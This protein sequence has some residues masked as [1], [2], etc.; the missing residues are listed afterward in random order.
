[1]R[2]VEILGQLAVAR[3][4]TIA[5]HRR[6]TRPIFAAV[7]LSMLV[8]CTADTSFVASPGSESDESE[9]ESESESDESGGPS[10]ATSDDDSSDDDSSDHSCGDGIVDPDEQCDDGNT[11]DWDACSNACTLPQCGDGQIQT[12]E[13][14]DL[15]PANGPGSTCTNACQVNVCGDGV[16]GPGETCDDGNDIDD[17]DCPN[18]CVVPGCGN[19]VLD[20][21]EECE[22]DN[23]I[24]G[25]GCTNACLFAVCGDGIVHVGH[26]ACDD[27]NPFDDDECTTTC[28]LAVCGDGLVQLDEQ[29]DD[30]N[31]VANDGCVDC[32]AQRVVQLSVGAWSTCALLDTGAVRC[33]GLNDFGQLGYGHTQTIGDDEHPWTAGD[34]PL[35]GIAVE[36]GLGHRH[37]C[38][39]LEGGTVRCWGANNE[40]QLGYGHTETIGDNETPADAG[41]VDV[42]GP[43]VQLA[44][45]Y[46][47]TC[48][49]LESGAVRCWGSGNQALGYPHTETIGDDETPADAGDIDLGGTAVAIAGKSMH[50]CALMTTGGVRCWGNNFRS[51]LGYPG[52]DDDPSDT[53]ASLGDVDLGPGEVASLVTSEWQTC[54]IMVGGALRCWGYTNWETYP[55]VI[56]SI[57]GND[58]TPAEA[59]DVE[60][61]DA[62]VDL[63]LASR[64]ACRVDPAGAV[65]C[66]GEES[67][68]GM[69]GYGEYYLVGW[70]AG[71]APIVQVGDPVAAIAGDTQHYC[72]LTQAGGVRCWGKSPGY[73]NEATVGDDEWPSAAGYIQVFEP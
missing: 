52:L 34:V 71:D 61:T 59:G 44:V 56:D 19:G 15:G 35:G 9:S 72:A 4:R 7:S 30:A 38:A 45:G 42:G 51:A 37:A 54:A 29:C 64:G 50:T 39:R 48:A 6:V 23:D 18:T 11:I 60:L 1:M 26:E 22:D 32:Q 20:P 27:G 40:G 62:V 66:W 2:Q 31:N 53:P 58:E 5:S 69:H 16:L 49:L 63:A 65:R 21:G 46:I 68:F 67:W 12:G 33:W 25:D 10:D 43:V 14:C 24:D 57:I 3:P 17:D 36:V 47:R 73:A 55:F 13:A 28:E 8:A 41:D 70:T